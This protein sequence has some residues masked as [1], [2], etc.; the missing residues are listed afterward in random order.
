MNRLQTAFI[1]SDRFMLSTA[2]AGICL[3][4]A[5]LVLFASSER[6]KRK[7]QSLHTQLKQMEMMNE[8]LVQLRDLVGSREKKIGLTEGNGIVSSLE[9]MIGSLGIEATSIKPL[10]KRTSGEF[11]EEKAELEIEN[12]DINRIVNLLYRIDNSPVP[13][14]INDASIRATFENPDQYILSLTASLI[15]K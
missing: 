2:V 3:I 12:I 7:N 1:I 5:T 10:E 9:A 15:G 6:L 14:K 4:V 8:E 13:L 11:I